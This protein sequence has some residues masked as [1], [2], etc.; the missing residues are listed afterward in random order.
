MR[1]FKI[2]GVVA[3][4]V[5]LLTLAVLKAPAVAGQSRSNRNGSSQ[6]IQFFGRGSHIGASVRDL[7]DTERKAGNGVYVEDVR[8][9]SAAE[10]AGLKAADIITRYDGENVRSA[11]Q[12]TRL[13]QETP[14]GRTVNETVRSEGR[15][16]ELSLT[17]DEG[18]GAG[19]FLN[20]DRLGNIIDEKR[21]QDR[22]AEAQERMKQIPFNFDF[23]LQFPKLLRRSRLGV[24]V[25]ELTPQLATYF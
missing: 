19:V 1:T 15:S 25:E 24:S 22:I 12:F 13:V 18:A 3:V 8:T 14:S 20:G 16:T 7:D 9:G 4:V 10:K 5:G 11:L 21:L 23:D 2:I 17:P 6:Q